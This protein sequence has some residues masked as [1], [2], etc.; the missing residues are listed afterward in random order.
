MLLV[1]LE[2]I[3]P[4]KD[5]YYSTLR[6]HML[7]SNKNFQGSDQLRGFCD[8]F[9]SYLYSAALSFPQRG[10]T[11]TS[12]YR[13]EYDLDLHLIKIPSHLDRES[14]YSFQP[15]LP[16]SQAPTESWLKAWN[17]GL[18]TNRL[19]CISITV[20]CTKLGKVL[21]STRCFNYVPSTSSCQE[22]FQGPCKV[23][24]CQEL[25][26]RSSPSEVSRLHARYF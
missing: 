26:L 2:S 25:L 12:C 1:A 24:S 19:A 3:S 14:I 15:P 20:K 18:F 11:R 5:I 21:G 6:C 4:G 17:W 22:S 8:R 23:D 10:M 9:F 7:P 16:R 13:F